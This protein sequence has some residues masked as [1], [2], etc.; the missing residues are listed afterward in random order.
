MK[1][2]LPKDNFILLETNRFDKENYRSFLFTNPVK[3]ISCYR[4]E[5]IEKSFSELEDLISKGYYAAGFLSYEAGFLFEDKLK[6]FFKKDDLYP[7]L[8]FGIYR[9]PAIFTHRE[10]LDLVSHEASPYSVSNIRANISKERYLC[11][12]KRIKEFI[13]RGETY[14]VNYTFKYKLSADPLRTSL[15]IWITLSSTT[16]NINILTAET[17]GYTTG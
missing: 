11:D 12:I 3:I 17:I 15:P 6:R 13:R 7:L 5:H 4:A 10:R 1:P 2:R 9:R 16:I 8:W 14:Q